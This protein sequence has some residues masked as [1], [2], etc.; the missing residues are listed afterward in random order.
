MSPTL[1]LR[2]RSTLDLDR[3]DPLSWALAPP[4]NETLV[5]QAARVAAQADAQRRS[6]AID[7]E[8]N[9]RRLEIKKAPKPVRVLLLGVSAIPCHFLVN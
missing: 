3:D 4:E 5:E 6:D 2:R 1:F 7:E 8:I 9:R